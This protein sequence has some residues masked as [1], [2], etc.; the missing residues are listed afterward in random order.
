MLVLSFGTIPLLVSPPIIIIANEQEF[1]SFMPEQGTLFSIR[2]GA[3][4]FS[5]QLAA[6]ISFLSYLASAHFTFQ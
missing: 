4:A 1:G 3:L 5:M 2:V 6:G